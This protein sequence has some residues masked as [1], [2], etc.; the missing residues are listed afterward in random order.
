[1]SEKEQSIGALW[2]K[3]EGGKKFM[4]GNVE[5]NGEKYAIVVFKNTYKKE[6]KHPD[7]RIYAARERQKQNEPF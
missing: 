2:V 6:D 5:I 4:T 7:Y 1:M 3:G